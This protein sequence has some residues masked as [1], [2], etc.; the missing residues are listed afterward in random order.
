MSL[1]YETPVWK[2]HRRVRGA[3][4]AAAIG[5]GSLVGFAGLVPALLIHG[6]HRMQG[7]TLGLTLALA[8]ALTL[9]CLGIAA[10]FSVQ[11]LVSIFAD[12]LEIRLGMF[13]L[14]IWT[15]IM[16]WP[17]IARCDVCKNWEPI[18]DHAPRI[19]V[20]SVKKF[21]A[22]SRTIG[23]TSV[24]FG[25]DGVRLLMRDKQGGILLGSDNP[26]QLC[27]LINQAKSE[28]DAISRS[29]ALLINSHQWPK[30]TPSTNS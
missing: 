22:L 28:T 2:E 10:T 15:R 26:Q 27:D 3:P 25:G 17:E 1:S 16:H 30:P 5:L 12:R 14:G 18:S 4:L 24:M 6:W 19:S 11:S 21:H 7:P 13:G 20:P 23:W 29:R 9:A 8:A